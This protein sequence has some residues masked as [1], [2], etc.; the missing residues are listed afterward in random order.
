MTFQTR[1]ILRLQC[2]AATKM[3]RTFVRRMTFRAIHSAFGNRMMAWKIE[4][5]THVTV[6]RETDLFGCSRR[7]CRGVCAKGV[8]HRAAGREAVGWFGFATGIRVN[9][10]RAMTGFTTGVQRVRPTHRQQG[11]VCGL[12]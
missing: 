8:R 4:L 11:V 1:F 6:T 12:E 5:T 3:D 9:A 2:C 7:R 10:G